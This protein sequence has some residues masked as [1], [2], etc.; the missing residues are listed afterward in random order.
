MSDL[1]GVPCS[2]CSER[3]H[4]PAKCPELTEPLRPGFSGSSGGGGHGGGDEDE[5]LSFLLSV[6]RLF[7][8][9]DQKLKLLVL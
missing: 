1:V 5:K 9:H 7:H 8:D 6:F 3:G 2:V 4:H